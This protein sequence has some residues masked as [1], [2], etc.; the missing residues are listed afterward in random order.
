M[1]EF[2]LPELGEDI[3][4]ATVIN[5]YVSKGDS[6]EE[7]DSLVELETD[8]AALDIPSPA[9]GKIAEVMVKSGDTIK[10]GDVIVKID[11]SGSEASDQDESEDSEEKEEAKEA[12]EERK[13]TEKDQ[14]QKEE[15]T[16]A[17][18]EKEQ[19]VSEEREEKSEAEPDDDTGKESKEEESGEDGVKKELKEKPEEQKAEKKVPE[20]A[21]A[22]A[23]KS[24][25]TQS[26]GETE[27]DQV[28]GD[29][30]KI[31]AA[32][33]SIR[34]LAR[35]LG[36][37]I[38]NISG[39]GPDGRISEVDVK[40]QAR[41]IISSRDSGASKPQKKT[42]TQ[43]LPDFSKWGEIEKIT[44][45]T[46]RRLTAENMT[47]AWTIPHV[48]QHDRADITHL[49][50]LRKKNKK[51]AEQEGGNLTITPIILKIAA[52]ALKL[53]PKF[54]SSIDV[55]NDEIIFKKYINIGFAVDTDRGLLVPNVRN[56]DKKNIIE[57][58]AELSDM[59]ERARNKKLKPE[60]M[61]G[62]T[63]SVSN[64]GGLGGTYFTPI[65]YYP[66]VA[67]LGVSRSFTEPVYVDGNL[68][69]RLVMPL[70]LSYD[71]RIIDGAEAVRFLRWIVEA[72]EEPFNLTLE[73]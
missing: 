53:F 71:H 56:T 3:E 39:S 52:A 10:I 37:D 32:S 29:S 65:I 26:N 36:L 8:K 69:P 27:K 45:P 19:K 43:P 22:E 57:I 72:L 15:S 68:E 5:V 14:K 49:D 6:V 12:K 47:M 44:M 40:N 4:T 46:V 42:L 31:P 63:F 9:K 7:E 54:N 11:D 59:S 23:K 28:S 33:P 73:G 66:E 30:G 58:S 38:N 67:M 51:K 21:P 35:E 34:R 48:T 24:E 2:R 61:Q 62:G 64:L 1:I 18:E 70:S 41:K 16:D 20:D 25:K 55:E 50:Q 17:P 60:E 13:V